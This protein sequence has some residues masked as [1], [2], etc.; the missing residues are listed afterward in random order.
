MTEKLGRKAVLQALMSDDAVEKKKAEYKAKEEGLSD[1]AK[2]IC[3]KFR[4]SFS[5]CTESKLNF[6]S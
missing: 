2:A 6:E 3:Q 4:V 1:A 5:L